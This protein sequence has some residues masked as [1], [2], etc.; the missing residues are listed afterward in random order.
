[1]ICM[2]SRGTFEQRL[3]HHEDAIMLLGIMTT[4]GFDNRM[5]GLSL[6]LALHCEVH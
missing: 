5:F 1:M 2:G 6:D 3:P 4:L